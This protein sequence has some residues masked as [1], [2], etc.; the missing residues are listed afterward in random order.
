MDHFG[1]QTGVAIASQFAAATHV[2]FFDLQET[3]PLATVKMFTL[4]DL[5]V[6]KQP[7]QAASVYPHLCLD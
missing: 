3:A 4:I 1:D 5:R 7:G 6:L 2:F